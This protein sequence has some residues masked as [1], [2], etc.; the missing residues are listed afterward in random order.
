ME[1]KEHLD[2]KLKTESIWVQIKGNAC[3][4]NRKSEG[5]WGRRGEGR[6]ESAARHVR[7]RHIL[8]SFFNF[9]LRPRFRGGA[10]PAAPPPPPRGRA[11]NEKL[12]YIYKPA[13]VYIF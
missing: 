2:L 3:G 1:E 6:G 9:P 8:F 10:A 5:R 12:T 11:P 7:G 13:C 4:E